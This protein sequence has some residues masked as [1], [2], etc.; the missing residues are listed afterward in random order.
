M[1]LDNTAT[2]K[3]IIAKLQSLEG[4][5]AKA[6]LASVVGSPATADDT[7]ATINSIL[8]DAKNEL[9]TKMADGSTGAEPLQTLVG[10]LSVGKRFASG[11]ATVASSR[12]TIMGL[13]FKPTQITL[14]KPDSAVD[15]AYGYFSSKDIIGNSQGDTNF[16]WSTSKTLHNNAFTIT[17][18]GFQ[19]ETTY[20][21]SGS[22]N[23]I[24]YE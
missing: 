24:A 13:E 20:M 22:I 8:Q 14:K 23:W 18:D 10:S 5:N 3:D 9:A 7:M 21:S 19:C 4:I 12:I 1:P 16:W 11:T 2:I 15:V 17:N 6:D